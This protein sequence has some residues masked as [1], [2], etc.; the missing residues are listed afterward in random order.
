MLVCKRGALRLQILSGGYVRPCEFMVNPEQAKEYGSLLESS[1]YEIYHSAKANNLREMVSEGKNFKY[2]RQDVCRN[3]AIGG[4]D[5]LQT[6]DKIPEYPWELNLAYDTTCNYRCKSCVF[7]K[8]PKEQKEVIAKIEEGIRPALPYAKKIIANGCGELF[9]S[10][11]IMRL[12][13]EWNPVWPAEE[14]SVILQTNGSLFDEIHW[15]KI[16]NIKK[17]YVD[18]Q[19]TIHSF[20]ESTYRFL[21]G[22]TQSVE[23]VV[24]N[25]HF[26]NGL[27]KEEIINH[28]EI[29]TVV[30]ER[31]FRELP[32]FVERCINEFDADTV[33]IRGFEPWGACD[34]N[35]E[36]F[37]NVRNPLHPYYEEY[38]EVMQHDIMKHPK[39]LNWMG[40]SESLQGDIPAKSSYECLK[41]FYLHDE[42][43]DAIKDYLQ[44]YNVTGIVLY[45]ISEMA[46]IL[47]RLFK[48]AEI[49]VDFILDKY[50]PREV[51]NELEVKRPSQELLGNMNGQAVLITLLNKAVYI[52]ADL[53]KAGY[54]GKFLELDRMLKLNKGGND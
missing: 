43:I 45:G 22:T 8:Y 2:C 39:V 1:L 47:Y 48:R 30:Q 41:L 19:I 4:T 35:V 6:V 23:R 29:A 42:P 40:Y 46:Q 28:F 38:L 20:N 13:A 49:N 24:E 51:W 5:F 27:R 54:N 31:N 18:A 3:L 21:S 52:K 36:W 26:V 9:A 14:C 17:Y 53:E 15:K 25:L 12:L 11:S 10:E 7:C 50:S 33:R 37:F 32:E 44:N 34:K 16:D